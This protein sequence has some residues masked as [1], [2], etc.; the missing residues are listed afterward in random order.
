MRHIGSIVD[1]DPRLRQS[2]L[3]PADHQSTGKPPKIQ[4]FCGAND[5]N[6]MALLMKMM[7]NLYWISYNKSVQCCFEAHAS[8]N[9]SITPGLSM[10]YAEALLNYAEAKAELGNGSISQ[11]DLDI[12]INKLR[13]RDGMVHLTNTPQMDPRYA[14]LGISA[15]LVEIRKKLSCFLKVSVMMI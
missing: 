13:D 3:H 8:Y 5:C 9:S 12:S 2:I 14:D 4:Y 15:A 7:L 6:S 1:R 11:A 10:R